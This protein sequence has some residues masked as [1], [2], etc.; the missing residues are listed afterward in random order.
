M[1]RRNGWNLWCMGQP[2]YAYKDG[3]KIIKAPIRPYHKIY[4]AMLPNQLKNMFR[5]NWRVL[6]SIMQGGDEI[7]VPI[8]NSQQYLE[9]TFITGSDRLKSKVE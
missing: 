7:K 3:D 4:C 8:E 1:N 6:F 2:S 5:T 9:D